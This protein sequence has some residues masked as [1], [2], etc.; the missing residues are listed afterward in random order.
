MND[1]P[2]ANVSAPYWAQLYKKAEEAHSRK[3]A[4]AIIHEAERL[5]RAAAQYNYADIW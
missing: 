5:R 4:I 2:T 3:E 1:H